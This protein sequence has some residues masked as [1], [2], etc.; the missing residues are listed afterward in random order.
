MYFF[1]NELFI[2]NDKVLWKVISLLEI[3]TITQK[4]KKRKFK[5]NN[6]GGKDELKEMS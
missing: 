3:I 5:G 1:V 4:I 2:I 6:V